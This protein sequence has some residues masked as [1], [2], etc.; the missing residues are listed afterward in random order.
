[1]FEDLLEAVEVGPD[2]AGLGRFRRRTRRL[3]SHRAHSLFCGRQCDCAVCKAGPPPHRTIGA[4][5]R[6]DLPLLL[7]EPTIRTY[8]TSYLLGHQSGE[9]RQH[10][11]ESNLQRGLSFVH[12][13][14]GRRADPG[15][16]GTPRWRLALRSEGGHGC[17]GRTPIWSSRHHGVTDQASAVVSSMRATST[18]LPPLPLRLLFCHVTMVSTQLPPLPLRLL[19][20][21]V[22]GE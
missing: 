4:K 14:P 20:R 17:T 21:H 18:Q 5:S 11:R 22:D 3:G 2:H 9:S 13:E 1:V 15:A 8:V 12:R 10:E 7:T 16:D 6:D 19:L